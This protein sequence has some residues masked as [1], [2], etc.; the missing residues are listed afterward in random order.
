MGVTLTQEMV[1]GA[2]DAH[3]K[4]GIPASIT[5][6]QIML[7][8][9]GSNKGGLSKLAADYNNLFGIKATPNNQYQTGTIV[10]S[11]KAGKD[12]G[13]YATF[14]SQSDSILEH[15]RI[16]SL[17]RYTSKIT[18]G[19]Y[20]DWANALQSGG[21]ATDSNYASKLISIIED[22]G[23][24]KYDTGASYSNLPETSTSDSGNSLNFF[25]DIAMVVFV[26]LLIVGGLLFF[27]NA[28]TNTNPI[29]EASKTVKAVKKKVKGK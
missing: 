10:M 9:S 17:D 20:S 1:K 16:L 8:S 7:E 28:F 4:Y 14:N 19:T 29:K 11:N 23:L 21:Y 15:S 18:S 13:T 2:Q 25:G 6:A 22:N 12:T 3:N 27:V 5:L 24:S 26:V